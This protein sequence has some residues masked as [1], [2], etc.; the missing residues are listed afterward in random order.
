M[1]IFV[2][3]CGSIGSRHIRNLKFLGFNNI[4][5]YD[6]DHHILSSFAKRYAIKAVKYIED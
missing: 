1:K 4:I 2:L 3:G 5:A 6:L